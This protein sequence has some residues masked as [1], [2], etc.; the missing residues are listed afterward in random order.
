M[1][2]DGVT[3]RRPLRVLHVVPAVAARYG[4][5]SQAAVELVRALDARGLS[6]TLA[7]TDADGP[8]RLAVQLR[9]TTTYSGV[10]AVFFERRRSESFKYSPELADW[11]RENVATFDV[12]HVHAVFSHAS[13]AA[14]RQCWARGVPYVLRPLGT[15]TPWA[16]A[17]KPVRKRV[18]TELVGRRMIGRAAAVHYTTQAERT[19]T[20][21]MIGPTA[22]V[23]VP[24][25]IESS[26]LDRDPT[27]QAERDRVLLIVGRLHPVK[28]IEAAIAAFHRV[29][30]NSPHAEWRLV[31][32]G[33]GETEY[34]NRLE[35][36][37]D[38]GPA[39]GLISFVGWLDDERKRAW[40]R[41][42]AVLV[43][44]SHQESFGVSVL[45]ALACGV[46]AVVSSGVALAE[47]VAEAGAGWVCEPHETS[48]ASA[49]SHV[50]AN[51]EERAR[52]GQAARRLAL[53]FTWTAA[54][55][56]LA[57]VYAD[58]CGN[59]TPAGQSQ[60]L[61]RGFAGQRR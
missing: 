59:E 51:T 22:G 20:E 24:L 12:L 60:A 58:V 47:D 9:T 38:Q 52:A 31:I 16:L 48:L 45:E 30:T 6:V 34:R 49:M 32:A 25:G 56:S 54:A 42:A 44:P 8:G 29:R 7:S 35:K 33:D 27:P 37:A 3:R 1:E 23:V 39:K 2:S 46:P 19:L 13:I 43:Q 40:L 26:W 61:T 5:P 55:E 11:L 21:S 10:P 14:A 15:L 4:G 18:L 50:M 36:A 57:D 28:N 17:Q 41:R 53:R